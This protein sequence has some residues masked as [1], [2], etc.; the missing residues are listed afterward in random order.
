[1]MSSSASDP[2]TTVDPTS[3]QIVV[4][5]WL[6]SLNRSFRNED[7]ITLNNARNR[8]SCFWMHVSQKCKA[9]D[10]DLPFSMLL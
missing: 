1:M 2:R 9:A 4:C 5:M 8:M 3:P 6:Q 7:L 10:V